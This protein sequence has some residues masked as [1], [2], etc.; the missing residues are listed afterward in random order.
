MWVT[1]QE[2][3]NFLYV[4]YKA[5]QSTAQA[6]HKTLDIQS[7]SYVNILIFYYNNALLKS[8]KKYLEVLAEV[9]ANEMDFTGVNLIIFLSQLEYQ[10][11]LQRDV[12]INTIGSIIRRLFFEKIC[13]RALLDEISSGKLYRNVA[14]DN[15]DLYPLYVEL[16]VEH[17]L[18][19]DLKQKNFAIFE[20]EC[21]GYYAL[22]VAMIK[23]HN[24][25]A[26]M[27]TVMKRIKMKLKL[28]IL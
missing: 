23:C 26:I 25:M 14:A 24:L 27:M 17:D 15:V 12:D 28:M 16:M 6:F 2:L 19:E 18:R 7:L 10:L 3:K 5:N 11:K 22:S 9:E 8:Y 1:R 4:C 21:Y 20:G 13:I